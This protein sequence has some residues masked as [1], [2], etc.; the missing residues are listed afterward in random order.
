MLLD[1]TIASKTTRVEVREKDGRYRVTLGDKTL[2]IDA[3]RVGPTAVSLLIDGM[4]HDVAIE[5][6]RTTPGSPASVFGVVIRGD[7][8]DVE[9]KEAVRGLESAKATS[10]G[11]FK[12]TAPIPGKIVKLLVN[13]GDT[14]EGGTSVLVMEAMKMENEL[15]AK[16]GGVVR[17][18][19]VKEGQAVETGAL[20]VVIG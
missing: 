14:I 6:I 3:L 9:L 12:L 5:S 2:E 4:S 18:I 8:F 15:K 20:L 16:R 19:K 1:A 17:E 7:R 10:S 11:P 13:A